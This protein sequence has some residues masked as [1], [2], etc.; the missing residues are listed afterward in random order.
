LQPTVLVH[1][2]YLRLVGKADL[3]LA[4]QKTARELRGGITR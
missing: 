4:G 3:P 2:A 1:E